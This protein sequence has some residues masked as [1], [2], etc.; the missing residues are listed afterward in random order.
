MVRVTKPVSVKASGNGCGHYTSVQRNR[1]FSKNGFDLVPLDVTCS[2]E[3]GI[4]TAY[5]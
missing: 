1:M 4:V 5:P 3:T 2:A